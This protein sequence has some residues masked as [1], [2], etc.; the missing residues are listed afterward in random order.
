VDKILEILAVFVLLSLVIHRFI[1]GRDPAYEPYD[2]LNRIRS[3]LAAEAGQRLFTTVLDAGQS[4]AFLVDEARQLRFSYSTTGSLT[5]H[6][7]QK[8]KQWLAAPLDC[9]AVSLDPEDGRLYLEAG[10]Y[11]FVYGRR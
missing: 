10:G 3:P 4:D 8:E 5:I 11:L 6:W 1:R 7:Q 9:T 2:Y